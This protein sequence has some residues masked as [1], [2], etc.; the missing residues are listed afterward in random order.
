MWAR[1]ETFPA[2]K[3]RVALRLGQLKGYRDEC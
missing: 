2:D 3:T 1:L